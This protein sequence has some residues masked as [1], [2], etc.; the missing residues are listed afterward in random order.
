MPSPPG[1]TSY[2]R[3]AGSPK[4][5]LSP[6]KVQFKSAA[7][8][9]L[10]EMVFSETQRRR[11]FAKEPQERK[12]K[13]YSSGASILVD[14]TSPRGVPD[15]LRLPHGFKVNT[16]PPLN[17]PLNPSLNPPLSNSFFD[18]VRR[19]Y[20]VGLLR[21]IGLIPLLLALSAAL[22]FLTTPSNSEAQKLEA[23]YKAKVAQNT[24]AVTAIADTFERLGDTF[25]LTAD[26]GLIKSGHVEFSKAALP[27][28]AHRSSAPGSDDFN[29]KIDV[30][31]ETS[32]E[33]DRAWRSFIAQHLEV[34]SDVMGRLQGFN[35]IL[36]ISTKSPAEI[37]VDITKFVRQDFQSISGRLEMEGRLLYCQLKSN[38]EAYC[39]EGANFVDIYRQL[40]KEF[41]GWIPGLTTPPG[42][43]EYR[44][45]TA[46]AIKVIEG[47]ALTWDRI[48]KDIK[49]AQ[50][51]YDEAVQTDDLGTILKALDKVHAKLHMACENQKGSN[52]YLQKSFPV[53]ILRLA[54]ALAAYR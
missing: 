46:Q 36:T 54:R 24:K 11:S 52:L 29:R 53:N 17:S 6:R 7:E 44:E 5:P 3:T 34:T 23:E 50:S 42:F 39:P 4:V 28:A 33:V 43:K 30:F 49:K 9:R 18:T 25:K 41:E 19:E 1:T 35:D 12:S 15:D 16:P 14:K 32:R 51:T 22:W 2:Q 20:R 31:I 27:I 10:D 37:H 8:Q 45:A 38:K 21:L 13:R 48:L 26:S 40:Q 47:I